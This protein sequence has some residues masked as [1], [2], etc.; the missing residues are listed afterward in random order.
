ME[1]NSCGFLFRIIALIFNF[2]LVIE[3]SWELKQKLS[4]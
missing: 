2:L 4:P 3:I 1:G